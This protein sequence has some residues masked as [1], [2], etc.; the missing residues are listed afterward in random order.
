MPTLIIGDLHHQTQH[1]DRI[2]ESEPHRRAVFLGDYFDA[3]GDTPED[4]RRTAA[5]VR[6]RLHEPDCTLLFGNHDLPYAYPRNRHVGCSGVTRAKAL[7]IAEVLSPAE[8][9]AVRLCSQVGPWLVSHAGFTRGQ[10]PAE[11]L[12]DSGLLARRCADALT[13]VR[14][15]GIDPL[16]AAGRERGGLFARGG[17][18]WCDWG[19]FEGVPGVH[20]IVGHSRSR[21]QPLRENRAARHSINLCIDYLCGRTYAVVES[22]QTVIKCLDEGGRVVPLA[23]FD[24]AELREASALE[25]ARRTP[26]PARPRKS[27]GYD[28][29][30]G[31]RR[32]PGLWA[33]TLRDITLRVER[34][35]PTP[36]P[37]TLANYGPERFPPP[38]EE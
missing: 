27:G 10:L 38:R 19:G 24:H 5:W 14:S 17:V 25:V 28:Y 36:P 13:A 21:E 12:L 31:P 30:V 18:T 1:A 34:P 4:A 3:E 2:R 37:R 8:W 6:E 33:T 7:A 22:G 29:R 15:G 23:S 35:N 16:V 20:Q 26:L 11:L 9:A 32:S